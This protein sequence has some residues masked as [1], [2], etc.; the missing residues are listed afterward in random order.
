MPPS[1]TSIL[2]QIGH[3]ACDRLTPV[4]CSQESKEISN[5][6]RFLLNRGRQVMGVEAVRD[7]T[8]SIHCSSAWHG[9]RL[10]TS[11]VMDPALHHERLARSDA[12]E[13]GRGSPSLQAFESRRIPQKIVERR[14]NDLRFC[15]VLTRA[16]LP[17]LCRAALVRWC[18][19][20]VA[21]AAAAEAA[22]GQIAE[23]RSR[24]CRSSRRSSNRPA[25][26]TNRSSPTARSSQ[27]RSV[28]GQ[29]SA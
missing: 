29:A 12:N 17:C 7:M 13:S 8:A 6:Q 22:R 2:H 1:H 27:R 3:R 28:D 24:S 16:M 23:L 14:E 10:V 21:A 26:D 11:P 18:A 4:A 9:S 19:A 15:R 20:D 25:R 5:D